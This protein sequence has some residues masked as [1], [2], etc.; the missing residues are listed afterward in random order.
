MEDLELRWGD[1]GRIVRLKGADCGLTATVFLIQQKV[2]PP[3]CS[4]V[5]F[6][7]SQLNVP[8]S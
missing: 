5:T 4:W 3:V 6:S 2:I 8:K 1:S 7:L